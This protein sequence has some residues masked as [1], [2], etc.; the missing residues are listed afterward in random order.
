[1]GFWLILGLK[2]CDYLQQ[3]YPEQYK[4]VTT[5]NKLSLRERSCS[6]DLAMADRVQKNQDPQLQEVQVPHVEQP[7]PIAKEKVHSPP[8]PGATQ[9]VIFLFLSLFLFLWFFPFS[10]VSFASTWSS[11]APEHRLF[12]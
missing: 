4:R 7:A 12:H 3:S 2:T 11:L 9:E 6:E 5:R 1:M 8:P 10:L